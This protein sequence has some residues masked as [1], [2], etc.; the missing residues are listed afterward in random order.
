MRTIK[1]RK[2]SAWGICALLLTISLL[3]LVTPAWS[4]YRSMTSEVAQFHAFMRR[5]PGVA[6]DLQANPRLVHN[7][8]YLDKHEE[9]R[10]FLRHHP[11][12]RDEI[13][14]NPRRVF[15]RYYIDDRRDYADNRP[16][17]RWDYRYGER[18]DDRLQRNDRERWEH[19]NDRD[20]REHRGD[21]DHR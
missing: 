9:V 6:S 12:V 7:R 19:R 10:E 4:D 20:N 18:R 8:N 5:H 13:A 16:Q 21:H 3:G 14:D 15:G 1:N 17:H 2:V 11:A